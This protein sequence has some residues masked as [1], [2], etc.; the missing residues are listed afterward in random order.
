MQKPLFL[1]FVPGHQPREHLSLALP[2]QD[3]HRSHAN[4]EHDDMLMK[5]VVHEQTYPE[6]PHDAHGQSLL[7]FSRLRLAHLI[8]EAG[9]GG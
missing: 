1:V 4:R 2:C 3:C 5:F 9:P 7:A 8:A 6:E